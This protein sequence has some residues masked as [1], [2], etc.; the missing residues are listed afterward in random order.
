ML[1]WLGL[2]LGLAG[3]VDEARTLL[4]RIRE[5]ASQAYAPPTAFAWVYIGLGEIDNAFD[6]LERAIDACD[7][8][9][10]PIKSYAFLDP[11]RGDPRFHALLRNMHLDEPTASSV[12][13]AQPSS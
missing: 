1:G 8:F 12:S 2:S 5:M 6:W 13:Q 7:Q 4:E 11:L 9:M 3:Q 10:M